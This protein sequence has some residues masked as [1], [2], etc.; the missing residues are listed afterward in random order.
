MF[1]EVRRKD[2]AES[3]AHHVVTL[4]LQTYSWYANFTRA[5]VIVCLLH[6]VSDIFLEAAKVGVNFWGLGEWGGGL[7]NL[8]A[9]SCACCTTSATYSSRPPRW[10]GVVGG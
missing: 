2:W 5:G 3:F 8:P 7:E 1:V 4:G 10:V 6:D 9:S